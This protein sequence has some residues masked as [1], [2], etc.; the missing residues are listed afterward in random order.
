[1]GHN[2]VIIVVW[3]VFCISLYGINS[4]VIHLLVLFEDRCHAHCLN[5]NVICLF[6]LFRQESCVFI[7]IIYTMKL[8]TWFSCLNNAQHSCLNNTN[9]W[10]NKLCTDLKRIYETYKFVMILSNYFFQNIKGPKLILVGFFNPF[11]NFLI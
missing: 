10:N 11:H 3:N 7:H 6:V 4:D 5:T 2:L 8:C 9:L 1:M